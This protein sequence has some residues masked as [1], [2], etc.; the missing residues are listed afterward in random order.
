MGP[1]KLQSEPVQHALA[2]VR[3][4]PSVLLPLL[5]SFV[6]IRLVQK[7]DCA[8]FQCLTESAPFMSVYLLD[9]LLDRVRLQALQPLSKCSYSLL[10]S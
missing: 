6:L 2:V 5:I 10:I 1:E 3:A 9:A 4:G 7:G 8:A